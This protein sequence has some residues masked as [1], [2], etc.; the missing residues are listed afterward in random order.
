MMK[1]SSI[2][3]LRQL[4]LCLTNSF[5][6][7]DKEAIDAIYNWIQDQG[8]ECIKTREPGGIKIAEDIRQV[9][10]NQDN[11]AYYNKYSKKKR[12]FLVI[13]FYRIIKFF[14]IV[15]FFKLFFINV[16]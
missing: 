6:I 13:Y 14:H 1:K 16:N 8:I 9:I 3:R 4:V 2:Y 15:I 12:L 7:S 5:A 11:T 10:L